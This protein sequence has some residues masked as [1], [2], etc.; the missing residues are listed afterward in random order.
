MTK[1]KVRKSCSQFACYLTGAGH[2]LPPAALYDDFLDDESD[3]DFRC[4]HLLYC[5]IHAILIW[6]STIPNEEILHNT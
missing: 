5:T 6:S 2:G 1:K 3:S 4:R